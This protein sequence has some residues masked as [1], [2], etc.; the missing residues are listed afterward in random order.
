V[1]LIDGIDG[2]KRDRRDNEGN[3]RNDGNCRPDRP[4]AADR[5]EKPAVDRPAGETDDE[6][7][8]K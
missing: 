8:Q 1:D 4:V 6:C 2:C 3:Y 5:A 7:R